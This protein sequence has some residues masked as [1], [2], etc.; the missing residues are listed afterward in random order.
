MPVTNTNAS[1]QEI[2]QEIEQLQQLKRELL[3]QIPESSNPL[4]KLAI[5]ALEKQ[6]KKIERK[7]AEAQKK[8]EERITASDLVSQENLD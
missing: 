3:A 4:M 2:N 7:I 1:V 8:L 6:I 5:R